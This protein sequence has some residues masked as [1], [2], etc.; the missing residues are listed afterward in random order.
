MGET[1]EEKLLRLAEKLK[2]LPSHLAQ[3]CFRVSWERWLRPRHLLGPAL[4]G[5][6]QLQLT[7]LSA[8]IYFSLH[9]FAKNGMVVPCVCLGT[10]QYWLI[11]TALWLYSLEQYS[12]YRF[13]ISH[14]SVKHFPE[15]SWIVVAFPCFT[16]VM[17]FTSWYGL[18]LLFSVRF[19]P[20]SLHCSSI[21]YSFSFFMHLLVLFFTSLYFSD[22]SGSNLFF[23]SS[24]FF[25]TDQEFLQ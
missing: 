17:P 22:P 18:L 1:I 10:V 5:C 14:S 12:V 24:L 25:R 13:S 3:S 8:M 9:F 15:R 2:R 7:F 20:I 19:T 23:L 16:M 6:C 21:Q 4:F 11:S